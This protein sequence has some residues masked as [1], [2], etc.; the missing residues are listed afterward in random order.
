VIGGSGYFFGPFVGAI[1]GVLLP[2]WL[3]FSGGL[4]LIFY[5]LLVMLLMAFCPTG[6]IGLSGRFFKRVSKPAP[7]SPS[8]MEKTA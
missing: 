7:S 3:R 5:A 8:A 6:L 2:E 4:Y 1:V